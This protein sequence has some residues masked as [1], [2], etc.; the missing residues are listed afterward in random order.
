M[1]KWIVMILVLLLATGCVPREEAKNQREER[2]EKLIQELISGSPWMSDL[3]STLFTFEEGNEGSRT[4]NNQIETFTYA[5]DGQLLTITTDLDTTV[6]NITDHSSYLMVLDVNGTKVQ[7]T[8]YQE[9]NEEESKEAIDILIEG[10]PWMHQEGKDFVYTFQKNGKG[11]ISSEADGY[12]YEFTYEVLEDG[13]INI[14]TVGVN[15][16]WKILDYK[17]KEVEVNMGGDLVTL[18]PYHKDSSST[19]TPTNQSLLGVWVGV[20]EKGQ[21]VAISL[22]ENGKGGL[23]KKNLRGDYEYVSSQMTY[24]VEGNRLLF[25]QTGNTMSYQYMLN[26]DKLVLMNDTS[27]EIWILTLSNEQVN[28]N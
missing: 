27:K 21:E 13:S 1:K 14:F 4:L 23:L 7:W 3:D 10:S 9:K 18:V 2:N 5:I 11:I 15:T 28:S 17:S 12:T 25:K 20:D 8:P 26:G 22:E 19:P 24:S 6:W 16:L